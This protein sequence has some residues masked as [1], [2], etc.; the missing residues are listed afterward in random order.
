MPYN[1]E[2]EWIDNG[3]WGETNNS[4]QRRGIYFFNRYLRDKT[5]LDIGCGHSSITEDAFTYD[6]LENENYDATFMK[7]I[8]NEMFDVVYASHVLEHLMIPYLAL[9][10][11]WRILRVDGFLI[12]AVPD[13][14]LYE[15][16]RE[17]PSRW[18]VDHKMFFL[19]NRED[20]PYTIN[21]S[22]F[23]RSCLIDKEYEIEYM[24]VCG[25]DVVDSFP[26]ESWSKDHPFP[27]YQIEMVVKKLA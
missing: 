22:S 8:G 10:N 14:D 27:E 9:R 23:I 15:G 17:L 1:K 5:V 12:I 4:S 24:D 19:S 20:L 18:N 7:E 2:G 21:F 26:N 3:R 16:K 25:D 6:Q 13:R 11:W